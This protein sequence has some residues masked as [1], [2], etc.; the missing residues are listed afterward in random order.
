MVSFNGKGQSTVGDTTA[1]ITRNSGRMI[2]WELPVGWNKQRVPSSG[3]QQ[4][5]YSLIIMIMAQVMDTPIVCSP[6]D[7][8]D[9][10]LLFTRNVN[11]VPKSIQVARA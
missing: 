7:Q 8:V 1:M 11:Y 3:T 9:V 6:S 5:K 10:L 2:A 4:V